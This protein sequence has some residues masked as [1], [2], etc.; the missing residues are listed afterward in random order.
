M[1]ARGQQLYEQSRKR[2]G[3]ENVLQNLFR[4]GNKEQTKFKVI[5]HFNLM[6]GF[7]SA[8]FVAKMKKFANIAGQVQRHGKTR[9][10]Y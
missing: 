5:L 8:K 7:T 9:K 3:R 10:C 6:L 1:S 2:K 4:D